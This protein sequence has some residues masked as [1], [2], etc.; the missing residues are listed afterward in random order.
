MA[1]CGGAAAAAATC[2]AA[3]AA[4]AAV[5]AGA[6]ANSGA[7]VNEDNDIAHLLLFRWIISNYQFLH[8]VTW[9]LHWTRGEGGG[10]VAAWG[11]SESVRLSSVMQVMS[12]AAACWYIHSLHVFVV[13]GSGAVVTIQRNNPGVLVDD[14]RARQSS[15]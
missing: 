15:A 12:L 7:F 14:F 3:A 6:G 5:A 11:G 8:V 13:K 1:Q 2:A 4:A 10:R 9:L